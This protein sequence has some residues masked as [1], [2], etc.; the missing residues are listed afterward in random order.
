VRSQ[1]ELNQPNPST[2]DKPRMPAAQSTTSGRSSEKSLPAILLP[3]PADHLDQSSHVVRYRDV[4]AGSGVLTRRGRMMVSKVSQRTRKDQRRSS[5][6]R[7][8][9]DTLD[10]NGMK[11]TETLRHRGTNARIQSL[12]LRAFVPLCLSVSVFF[13]RD[14]SFI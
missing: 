11:N 8:H 9:S 4:S 1:A 14:G 12:F 6:Q 10:S 2:N 13:L 3:D 7:E 5:N